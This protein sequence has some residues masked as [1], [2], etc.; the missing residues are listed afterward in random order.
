MPDQIITGEPLAQF[1]LGFLAEHPA[2]DALDIWF[3]CKA[4]L[5][6]IHKALE[7]LDKE[8]AIERVQWDA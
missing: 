5:H 2:A 4:D 6:D 8:G 3:A 1:I 7:A